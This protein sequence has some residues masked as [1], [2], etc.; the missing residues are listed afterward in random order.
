MKRLVAMMLALAALVLFASGAFAVDLS[1][2]PQELQDKITTLL[3]TRY[4]PELKE[5]NLSNATPA[6][7][8]AV[9]VTIKVY[10]DTKVTEDETSAV[11]LE[12]T[13]DGG[14]TWQQLETATD[15]NKT[16][17]AEIPG[18]PSGTEVMYAV[19]AVDSSG[20]YFMDVPCKTDSFPPEGYVE[21]S[22][23]ESDDINAACANAVPIACMMPMSRDDDPLNDEDDAIPKD[24]DFL[25][26]RVGYNDT[27][28]FVDMAAEDKIT[29]GSASPMDIR[30][31]AAVIVNPDKGAKGADLDT[32]LTMGGFV[33]EAPLA[34][35][36]GGMVKPCFYG[37]NKGGTFIQDEKGVD[38]SM[39]GKHVS[40]SIKRAALGAN[41]SNQITL[42]TFDG[43]ITSISPIAGAAWDN[44]HWTTLNMTEERKYTV[45]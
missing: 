1:V 6:A 35:I 27:D 7:D 16:W 15:D 37:Y 33:L 30:A 31:Y 39:K 40:F 3:S 14:K 12:Y 2:L 17:T 42:F 29:Q 32:L 9:T 44:N 13:T 21:A 43:H 38:C 11:Y 24:A 34:K 4:P 18:Q 23:V 26:Y 25:D 28:I 20:N 8:E 41:P 22:C 36:A 19:K 10:N 5:I 45:Q